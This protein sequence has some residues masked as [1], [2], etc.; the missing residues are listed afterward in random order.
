MGRHCAL[1][2]L[3]QVGHVETAGRLRRH[4]L[5]RWQLYNAAGSV[6]LSSDE[7][8]RESIYKEGA[9]ARVEGYWDGA[10]LRVDR[11]LWLSE[12]QDLREPSA[13]ESKAMTSVARAQ[14]N[15]RLRRFFEQRDYL[16]VQT[17]CWVLEPGTDL[18]LDPFRAFY[19]EQPQG[20][21]DEATPDDASAPRRD[22]QRQVRLGYLQTSPEFAMKALLSEGHE[23]IYQLTRAWRNGELTQLHQPEFTILEWYMAWEGVETLIDEVEALVR[24]LLEG[25]A[26]VSCGDYYDEAKLVDLTKPFERLSMQEVFKQACGFDLLECL[27]FEQLRDEVSARFEDLKIDRMQTW[28]ELFFLLQVS[29]IDPWLATKDAI[30]VTRW[31]RP[32]AVLARADAQD[33]R[34]AERFELYIRGVELCN[35]FGELTDPREQRLRFS[36]DLRERRL[37][38]LPDMP[39]PEQFLSALERGMPPSS[40]V[41][42]GVDRLLMLKVGAKTI[43][44]VVH[45]PLRR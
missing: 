17:P 35:G 27:S 36:D 13:Q 37:R 28:D 26:I 1:H 38:R 39:M 43:D 41:A 16:E 34:V 23:R 18:H 11:L 22:T 6:D 8:A 7:P 33:P 24:Q 14:L 2:R 40:G 29:F 32:L 5:G 20:G 31:P 15:H 12:E 3:E 10:T 21:G 30:F 19:H 42:V 4:E 9:L 44:E 45:Q 25:R